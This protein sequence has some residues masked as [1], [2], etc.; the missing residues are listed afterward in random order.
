MELSGLEELNAA[1]V[2]YKRAGACLVTRRGIRTEERQRTVSDA[3]SV[4]YK[5]CQD[6]DCDVAGCGGQKKTALQELCCYMSFAVL[7]YRHFGVHSFILIDHQ[8]V[9]KNITL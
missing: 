1:L 6:K 7:R 5:L 4:N 8:E 9:P 2:V 3:I